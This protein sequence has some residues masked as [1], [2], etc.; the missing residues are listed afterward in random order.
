M[1]ELN[2]IRYSVGKPQMLWSERPH[3]FW[4]VHFTGKTDSP[5][6]KAS[7]ASGV[8]QHDQARALCF[9]YARFTSGTFD[10]TNTVWWKYLGLIL[11]IASPQRR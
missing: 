1:L 2:Q 11:G 5:G 7:V 9:R 8:G 3:A 4:F 10:L 6:I